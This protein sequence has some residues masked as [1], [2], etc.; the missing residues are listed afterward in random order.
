MSTGPTK[1][2]VSMKVEYISIHPSTHIVVFVAV[3]LDPVQ[4]DPAVALLHLLEQIQGLGELRFPQPVRALLGE[5]LREGGCA[6]Q[7]HPHT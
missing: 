2:H 5:K 4:G 3:V 6:R 1:T 7:E